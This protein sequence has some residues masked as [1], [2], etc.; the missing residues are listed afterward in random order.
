MTKTEQFLRDE[1]SWNALMEARDNP[2]LLNVYQV[3]A[4]AEIAVQL[5]RANDR[6]ESNAD[7]SR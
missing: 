2:G 1:F 6:E 3:M 5:C 7:Q 4:L